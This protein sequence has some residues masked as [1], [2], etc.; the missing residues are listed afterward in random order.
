VL[1]GY[2][3]TQQSVL[4][5]SAG[6]DTTYATYDADGRVATKSNPQRSSSSATDGYTTYHYDALDRVISTLYPDGASTGTSVWT[7]NVDLLTDAAGKQRKLIYDGA[8]RLSTVWEPGPTGSFDYETDYSYLQ[9]YSTSTYQT[10]VNQKGGSAL[11]SNWHTRT[12]TTDEL[13]RLIKEQTPEAGT[14]QYS[15]LTSA[16]SLC[17]G[18]FSAVC[19]RTDNEGTQT[20]Y[21]YDAL[22]R[23]TGTTYADTVTGVTVAAHTPSVSYSY[24]QSSYNGLTISNGIGAMTGM[25]DG[26]GQTAWSFD[27]L[28]R[29]TSVRKTIN[30][31]TKQSTVTYN[32]DS[33]VATM[34]DFG[35]TTLTYGYDNTG[36]PTSISDSSGDYFANSASYYPPGL[37][38]GLTH[39]ISGGASYSRSNQYNNLLQPTVLSASRTSSPTATLMSYSYSYGTSGHNNGDISAIQ[40]NVNAGW[41][42][43]FSYDNLNRLATASNPDSTHGTGWTQSFTYDPW[44][45]LL[46]ESQ[47]GSVSGYSPSATETNNQL[48]S[49]SYDGAGRMTGDGTNT[50]TYDAE[51]RILTANANSYVYDGMGNRVKTTISGTVTLY[52][53]GVTGGVIDE[54]D[55]TASTMAKQVAF[56]GSLVW[57]QS[58]HGGASV[59]LFQDHLGSTKVTADGSGTLKDNVS[60]YPY[61][62]R[63]SYSSASSDNHYGFTGDQEDPDSDYSIF[64]N[65]NTVWGRFNRPDPYLGSYDPTDPQSL[66]RYSYVEN[67]PIVATD[68][69]GL[70]LARA[71]TNPDVGYGGLGPTIIQQQNYQMESEIDAFMDATDPNSHWVTITLPN[72][73]QISVSVAQVFDTLGAG[74]S[75][76][77]DGITIDPS[78]VVSE[79]NET[80]GTISMASLSVSGSGFYFGPGSNT[81]A[82]N[83]P[84]PPPCQNMKWGCPPQPVP[85]PKSQKCQA[86]AQAAE[87]KAKESHAKDGLLMG[88]STAY[89]MSRGASFLM[90]LYDAA[91]GFYIGFD[92]DNTVV[93]QIGT[94]AYRDCMAKP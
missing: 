44:A 58:A 59:F 23:P 80:A 81:P 28:G 9:N 89:G 91:A 25:S 74:Q 82:P 65:L 41:N 49:I 43:Q 64:R 16:F 51:G 24:D 92:I 18:N 15:Y 78:G 85:D 26:S 48:S 53:P 68:S 13:G 36:R 5:D 73:T 38:A 6:N 52:W 4:I 46:S 60:Y 40:D 1:D 93:D 21:V 33:S 84:A 69:T 30:G 31:Y 8:G 12:F 57:R 29:P 61:G 39:S 11:S 19:V 88:T 75:L 72:G 71:G 90:G 50:Y 7:G 42:Q 17:T 45:N 47:T 10:I 62:G 83:K 94:M 70:L 14:I 27:T 63:I 35:G 54:S 86:Q 56:G 77:T 3:R 79:H 55:S 22:D 66:N 87:A 20:T 67:M 2:G 76:T 32:Y 34:S 37:L